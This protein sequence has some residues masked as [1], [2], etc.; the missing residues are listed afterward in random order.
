V[1]DRPP[2]RS[3][4]PDHGP[5]PIATF[6]AK[7]LGR[8]GAPESLDTM[9]VIFTRWPE[10]VGPELAAHLHPV[11]VHG[12]VLVIGADHPAWVT[13]CRMDAEH[14]IAAARAL[15]DTTVQR[16]EVVLQRPN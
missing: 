8:L 2:R 5:Q 7:V 3:R 10:V 15:G 4:R 12:T 13:R 11:R 6:M 14:I 1:S 9:E 16:I